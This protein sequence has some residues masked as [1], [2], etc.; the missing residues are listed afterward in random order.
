MENCYNKHDKTDR[1]GQNNP[2]WGLTASEESN[3]LR[4]QAQQIIRDNSIDEG[5]PIY[6]NGTFYPSISACKRAT[7]H[8]RVTIS[9]WKDD[10]LKPECYVPTQDQLREVGLLLPPELA[11]SNT[12]AP[13]PVSL[14]QIEYPSLSA[15]G[16]A[17][18]CTGTKIHS[19]IQR[20]PVNCFY[21]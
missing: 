14:Y 16:R 9:N 4:R 13:K 18:G 2:S 17:L 11:G 21:L 1:I 19:L 15:A 10:P 8:S 5:T 3:E 12:G 6:L 7:G 20:D